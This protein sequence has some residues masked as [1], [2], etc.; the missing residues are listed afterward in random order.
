MVIISIFE[1]IEDLIFPKSILLLVVILII[2]LAEGINAENSNNSSKSP[3]ISI[4]L[5]WDDNDIINGQEFNIGVSVSNLQEK[6]YDVKIFI[7]GEDNKI[8]SQTY[9][10]EK[11][12]TSNNYIKSLLKGSG[13]EQQQVKLRINSNYKN[14]KGDAKIGCRIRVSGSSSYQETEKDISILESGNNKDESNADTSDKSSVDD[15]SKK[16]SEKTNTVKKEVDPVKSD[17]EQNTA[18]PEAAQE[19]FVEGNVIK[20]GAVK[21]QAEDIKTQNIYESKSE[22]V[23]KY[24]IYAFALICVI[25]IILLVLKKI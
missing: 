23:K 21:N 19:D 9:N 14:F 16:T 10:A 5:N 3:S 24:L 4:E 11:W 2:L 7:Y 13:D 8:I 20:L 22:S 1:K 25:L 17:I 15:S 18:K 12:V 6:D